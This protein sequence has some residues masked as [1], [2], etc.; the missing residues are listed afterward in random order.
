MGMMQVGVFDE[1]LDSRIS[2]TALVRA[3]YLTAACA[4]ASSFW[5]GDQVN[6]FMPRSI[7]T[8][9]Y[10]GAARLVPRINAVHEPW[11]MLGY[12]AARHPFGRLQLGIGVT[13]AAR[14]NPAVTAQAAATL[15]LLTRGR[16]I[17]GIG[18]GERANNEPYGVNWSQPVSRFE[19]AIATIRA[20]WD[21]GGRLVNRDSPHFPLKDAVFDLPPYRGCWPQLWIAAHGPRMLN[22]TGRY[23]D[24]WFPAAIARP[25]DYANRLETVRAAASDA[26]RDPT[27]ITPALMTFAV[28]GHHR[29]DVE[30]ALDADTVKFT[31][32]YASAETWSRHGAQHPLAIG[33]SSGGQDI[34]PQT[35]DER[36]ARDFA[37]QVPASLI[38]EV[39]LNGI[40]EEVIDRAAELRDHG[41]R[42]L[43][44]GNVSTLQSDLR[45]ALA[46]T[47]PFAKALRGMRKL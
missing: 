23:A 39:V 7:A 2:P 4:G 44:V 22:I 14:R 13:D 33:S 24:A 9:Q 21:S 46:S 1:I 34:I 32:L 6:L 43:V 36:A 27:A 26:G 35:I 40:P 5:V 47:W 30:E 18:T 11:T 45:K 10:M 3:K 17:L 41:L 37:A 25:I 19:E 16:A 15:N 38:K 12:L 31:A 29:D 8:P 28:V 42:H 20:L